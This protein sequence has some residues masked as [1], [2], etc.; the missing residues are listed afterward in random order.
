[1][2]NRVLLRIKIIQIL[3]SYYKSDGKSLPV[4]EKEL[5]HSIEKTYDLYFHLLQL[6][7]EITRFAAERIQTKR[8]KLRPTAEDINPNTRFIDNLFVAQLSKNIEFND[9][10]TAHKLSWVN[11]P[12][13]VKGLYE[14][15]IASDFFAEYMNAPEANYSADKDIWRKIFKKILLQSEDLDDSIQDQSIYWTDDIEMVIS[16]IIKTIKRFDESKG[17]EQPLLPMFK[18]EEDAEFARKLI[19]SV[20]TNG[21]KYRE[22]IDKNTRNWELDR[23]AFMDIVIMEVALAELLDFPTIP[24]NVTL[25]EYIEI[26]KNYSTEKS[27]TF[28]NGVLDN[29]VGDLKKENKLIKVVMFSDSKKK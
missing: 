23:I 27:G 16:F 1:M 25:N 9:Y 5:F 7:I 22:M 18:D 13:I 24:V 11:H 6:T 2:I 14:K 28:I 29:I 21:A 10:L 19:R 4:A 20:L 8:N 17:D 26:A 12:D 3:Y 15:I